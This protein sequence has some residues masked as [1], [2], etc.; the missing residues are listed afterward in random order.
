MREVHNRRAR[1]TL[2]LLN[3]DLTSD[4]ESPHPQRWLAEGAHDHLHPLSELPHPIIAK[5]SKAFGEDSAKD[6]FV[7]PITSATQL[8]LLEI[9]QSQWR[10]G[11]WQDNDSGVCWLVVAGL[12]K[13]GHKDR[14]DFYKRIE[15]EDMSGNL[16]RWRPTA[17]DIRL[18][19]RETAAQ[20]RTTW[21][22]NIQRQIRDLLNEIQAGGSR[23]FSIQHPVA[24][25]DLMAQLELDIV[26]VREDGYEADEVLLEITPHNRFAGTNLMWQLT[27]RVLTTISPPESGWDRTGDT[28]SNIG[29]VGEW[30][31]RVGE[32][33]QL[34]DSQLLSE[35]EPGSVSHYAHR[36]HLAKSTVNG[37]AVRALCGTFFVPTQDHSILSACPAC[38]ERWSELPS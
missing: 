11:V 32:L 18:L 34:I 4:W 10:G 16:T 35:S 22:F 1:P 13:G 27:T 15:R 12:A 21:E 25:Q 28:Y 31:K 36:K 37:N 7:G 2:R 38:E 8:R 20:L 17:E 5:A 30:A 9:K 29:D 26:P 19:K 14:D 33:D 24:N 3:E 6:N 23:K